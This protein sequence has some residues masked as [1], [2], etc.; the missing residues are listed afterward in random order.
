MSEPTEP[1]APLPPPDEPRPPI[2]TG[3]LLGGALLVLFGVAWLLESLDV[4]EVPWGLFLPGALVA[5]GAIL[6]VNA[7]TGASHRGMIWIGVVLTFL[8]FLGSAISFPIEGGIGERTIR[9]TGSLE[10]TYEL[11]IGKL[12]V[13]L[14]RFDFAGTDVSV[15]LDVRLGVGELVVIV[16]TDLSIRVEARS[17]L[18]NVVVFGQEESGIDA[19]LTVEAEGTPTVTLEATVGIGE[20]V[21]ERG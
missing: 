12:T 11:G 1:T 13:D 21:V 16:P 6:V 8:L 9:P 4:V 20:V 10:A 14:T 19:Q 7:R 2:R 5:I 17:A 3:R 18:G 15:G